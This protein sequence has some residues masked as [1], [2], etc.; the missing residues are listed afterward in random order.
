MQPKVALQQKSGEFRENQRGFYLG[1]RYLNT[2]ELLG[3]FFPLDFPL[4]LWEKGFFFFPPT[5]YIQKLGVI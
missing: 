5:M 2:K 1:V 4:I 3:F